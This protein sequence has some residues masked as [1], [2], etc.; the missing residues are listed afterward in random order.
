MNAAALTTEIV[1]LTLQEILERRRKA[2]NVPNVL[3]RQL[4][5]V[6]SNTT[7]NDLDADFK[8]DIREVSASIAA[9]INKQGYKLVPK[10]S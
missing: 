6:H 9:Y 4:Q 7:L 5:G 1:F 8:A 3:M 10:D 2:V